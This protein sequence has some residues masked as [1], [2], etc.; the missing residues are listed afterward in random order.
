M[1]IASRLDVGVSQKEDGEDDGDHVPTRE[2]Q[3]VLVNGI[4]PCGS[5][6]SRESIN[7]LAHLA[8]IV[9]STKCY[10]CRDLQQ[11]DLKCI[12]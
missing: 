10:H 9:E 11:A 4:P 3:S 6:N 12:G 7:D 8:R 1:I 5:K 2:D